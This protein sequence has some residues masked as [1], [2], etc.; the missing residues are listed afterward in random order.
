MANIN[1]KI[2]PSNL[3][4]VADR[5]TS[6]LTIEFANQVVLGNDFLPDKIYYDT[7]YGTDPGNI[8][9]VAVNWLDF[10][11]KISELSNHQNICKYF[12]D[13]KGVGYDVVRKIIEVVRTILMSLQYEKLEFDYG[14]MSDRNIINAGI[15]Y[16]NDLR[17]SQGVVSG[18]LMYECLVLETNDQ[19]VPIDLDESV[20]TQLINRTDKYFEYK[21]EY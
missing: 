5:L 13:V 4:L 14:I 17:S 10:N 21:E 3:S 6:V 19:P 20:Y 2:Q 9:Y 12:I 18:G 8:P 7:D 11:N 1:Y 15:D 16:E